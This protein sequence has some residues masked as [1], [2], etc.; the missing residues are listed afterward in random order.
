MFGL[1]NPV[2]LGGTVDILVHA[3]VYVVVTGQFTNIPGPTFGFVPAFS[4]AVAE[5]GVVFVPLI[6]TVGGEE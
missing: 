4:T 5:A 3:Y 2:A 6:V 1:L